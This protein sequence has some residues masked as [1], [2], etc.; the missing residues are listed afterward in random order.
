M[1]ANQTLHPSYESEVADCN[2][3]FQ[4]MVS[5]IK[6]QKGYLVDLALLT[7]AYETAKAWHG[8]TRRHSGVLYLRH[9]LAVME[10]LA[11]LRCKTSVLAAALLH[12][13]MED[14]AVSF[15]YLRENFTSEVA[16]IV[17]SVT[18]IKAEEKEREVPE[19]MA[20][21]T[22][23]ERHVF[24]D[25][26]TDS[27][28]I[29]AKRQREAF[30]VRF[31]DR[32]HNLATID[33]CTPV[34]RKEK[35]ASTRAFLIPAARKLGMRYFA[36]LLEDECMRF[37]GEDY[38]DNRSAALLT[39]RNELMR[40]GSKA[41]SRL[42]QVL[43]DALAEQDVFSNPCFNPFMKLR[44]FRRTGGEE[45]Q[46]IQ[47]RALLAY[48]LQRQWSGKADFG[49][50]QVDLWEI[51]LTARESTPAALL[52]QFLLLFTQPLRE[53]NLFY[54]YAGQEEAAVVIRLTDLLEN[55]YRVVL[56]PEERL[57]AYFIGDT[58]G[59]RLTMTNEQAPD[60]A[61][62]AQMTV[63]TYSAHKGYRKYEKCVPQGA[64]ALD[65]AF[66]VS[67]TLAHTTKGA[68]I[69]TWRGEAHTEAFTADDY[70]YPMGTVL[71]DGDVVHYDADYFPHEPEKCI[72]HTTI[73]RFGAINTEYARNCLIHFFKERYP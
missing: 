39:R 10:E 49:R 13:T 42:D 44:G 56:V 38:T 53:A 48:E 11:R 72:Y 14:C 19:R 59:A 30:L 57:E 68:W 67:P 24:L 1:G 43:Q 32:A 25:R 16:E 20:A 2:R 31:A 54:E 45:P 60:H 73:D 61:L 36:I 5:L 9:P 52:H 63:Y 35:I 3:M 23:Q 69:H 41:Y 66:I 47:R 22:K 34:K 58:E 6:R 51:L 4:T 8:D 40:V 15:E 37:D 27:K 71:N 28:L 70:C 64:T 55:R 46:T 33:A 29:A 18:A 21:M 12:D 7:K 65:F 26:L 17:D 50:S 62:R